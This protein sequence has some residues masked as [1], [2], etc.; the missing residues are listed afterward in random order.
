MNVAIVGY[1]N[2]GWN[3]E[4]QLTKV[5]IK[6]TQIVSYKHSGNGIINN[7]ESIDPNTNVVFVCKSDSTISD[8]IHVLSKSRLAD[9]C[10]V[11]HTSGSVQM[12]NSRFQD[13]VFYPFQTFTRGYQANWKNVPIFIE[14]ESNNAK[15][16]LAQ[17]SLKIDCQVQDLNSEQRKRLHIAGVFSSNFP[18]HL[19]RL[20]FDFLAKNEIDPKLIHPLMVEAIRKSFELGPAKAQ[21]GPAMRDDQMVIEKHL[22]LLADNRELHSLY[23]QFTDGI[24]KA[25]Q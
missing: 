5:G 19:I 7:I 12:Q 15:R 2:L 3:L 6:V 17:I 24:Q 20:M 14:T 1:G 10:L 25:N 21:T 16:I 4:T 9:T 11:A 8:T 13:A 22:E 18:N 23:T